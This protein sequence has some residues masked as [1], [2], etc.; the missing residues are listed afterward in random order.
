[1]LPWPLPGFLALDAPESLRIPFT[2]LMSSLLN[3]WPDALL[4]VDPS[5][6]SSF[7]QPVVLLGFQHSS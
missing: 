7:A 6:T 3:L 5:S 4:A 2:A 1:M